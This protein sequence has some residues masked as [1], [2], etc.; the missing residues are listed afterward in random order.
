MTYPEVMHVAYAAISWA[1]IYR[2]GEYSVLKE[3]I[4]R[5]DKKRASPSHSPSLR[6]L[7]CLPFPSVL[8]S[9][10][11]ASSPRPGHYRATRKVQRAGTPSR[12]C[13]GGQGGATLRHVCAS[14]GGRRW[15]RWRLDRAERGS[16]QRCSSDANSWRG[17]SAHDHHVRMITMCA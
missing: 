7:R 2:T 6:F 11:S 14:E 10:R 1:L 12:K 4:E 16:E 3:K 15:A 17:G 9:A 8:F 5:G 13:G